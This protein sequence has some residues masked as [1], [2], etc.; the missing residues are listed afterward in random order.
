MVVEQLTPP[1]QFTQGTTH[2]FAT[3]VKSSTRRVFSWV[4]FYLLSTICYRFQFV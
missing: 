1:A 3:V 4:S 2:C